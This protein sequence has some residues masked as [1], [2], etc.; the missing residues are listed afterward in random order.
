MNK[1][2][3]NITILCLVMI[4]FLVFSNQVMAANYTISL[5]ASSVTKGKSTTLYIRCSDIAGG[6][7]VTSS[8]SN[9]A[10]ISGDGRIWCDNN[11]ETITIS[12][13]VVGSSTIT[14]KPIS[15]TDND[16]NDISLPTK[17]LTLSVKEPVVIKK[18]SDANLKEL[19]IED[20]T[21]SPEFNKD[22]L[23]Y[24]VDLEPETT[25][26]NVKASPSDSK[27][28]VKGNGEVTV[29]D[30]S[31]KLEIIVTAEDGTAKTYVIVANV[32]EL[33][34]IK[35]T[36]NKVEYSV[37]RKKAD[38]P[39]LELFDEAK[40]RINDEEVIAY[41]NKNLDIYIVA[42]KDNSGKSGLYIYNEKDNSY[43]E[44]RQ[45][46]IGNTALYLKESNLPNNNYKEYKINI[47]DI[48]TTIYKVNK[49]DKVGLI[50]GVN[51]ITNN[52]GYY[53]YDIEEGS[54]QRYYDK[55]IDIYKDKNKEYFVALMVS[56]GIITTLVVSI[57]IKVIIKAN[58]K[59]KKY[60]VKK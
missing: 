57:L 29:G 35:V 16:A 11:T 43:I 46:M 12:T 7:A 53:V 30:G 55:E 2:F 32:K 34:P 22:T 50:Y 48:D 15:V 17:T 41:H 54:L 45:I 52:E 25:K 28:S 10:S 33:N 36:V 58:K 56:L 26:I 40:V 20:G 18:S 24:T 6:F 21:L 5:G 31:N 42:L 9:V 3:K 49:E 60:K 37:V 19:G 1:I 27:A 44:Y 8:N 23:E 13:S 39:K 38:L 59:K 51:I 47:S 4:T 14:V